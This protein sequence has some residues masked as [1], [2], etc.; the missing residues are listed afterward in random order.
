MRCGYAAKYKA[1]R[2]PTC[3]CLSC[4]LIWATKQIGVRSRLA[5]AA[6]LLDPKAPENLFAQLLRDGQQVTGE[7]V[8]VQQL[9]REL[10]RTSFDVVFPDMPPALRLSA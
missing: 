7:P 4:D 1:T 8:G 3:G 10:V 9:K 5:D 2:A 6:R